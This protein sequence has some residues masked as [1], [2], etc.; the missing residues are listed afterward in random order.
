MNWILIEIKNIFSFLVQIILFEIFE[1]G[2]KSFSIKNI[3]E[4][5]FLIVLVVFFSRTIKNWMK[6]WILV[7]L[8]IKKGTR[9]AIASIINYIITITGILIVLHNAGID[10][11]SIT[12]IAGALSIGIGIGLKNIISNFVSGLTILI[13]Q[14]IKVGDFIEVDDL[15]GVVEKTS[16][17]STVIRTI[18]GI[19]VIIPNNSIVEQNIINWSHKDSTSRLHIPIGVAYGSD[20]DLVKEALLDAARKEKKVLSNPSPKVWFKGFGDSALNFELLVWIKYPT[21]IDQIKSYLNFLI[22]SELSYRKISIPF[23]QRDLHIRQIN[24]LIQAHKKAESTTVVKNPKNLSTSLVKN[25]AKTKQN[26]SKWNLRDLLRQI[27][28]FKKCNNIELRDV[29]ENGYRKIVPRGE[30][31]CLEGESGDSFYIILSGSVEVFSEKAN[32][33]ITTRYAGEF[34]GEMS[35]ILGI[36]RTASLRA[37]E[38]TILFVV[39]R[40]NLHNLLAKHQKLADKISEELSRRL[41]TLKNLGLLDKQENSQETAMIWIRNRIYT[42]FGI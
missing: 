1:L 30:I 21:L 20:T 15:S 2:N 9:E 11:T 27:S 37:T 10:L 40:E 28:Y 36:T 29:I 42:L 34:I 17:R 18:D 26:S 7:N 6:E 16:I 5:I 23:P 39:D 35:L 3:T 8:G 33:Y 31:I 38:D 32:K 41:E 24:D 19:F 12:V 13:A 14:P 25:I 22:Y 4:I